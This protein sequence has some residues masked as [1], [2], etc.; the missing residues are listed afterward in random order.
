MFGHYNSALTPPAPVMP[1]TVPRQLHPQPCS[2]KLSR[3]ETIFAE[4]VVGWV[5]G[6]GSNFKIQPGCADP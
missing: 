4:G 5:G 2:V 3:Q 6:G 1:V